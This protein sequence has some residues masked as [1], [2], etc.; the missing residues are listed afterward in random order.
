MNSEYLVS[1]IIPVYNAERCIEKCLVS[2]NKQTLSKSKFEVLVVDDYSTDGTLDKVRNHNTDLN[3]RIVELGENLGP[4]IARNKGIDLARGAYILFLDG[5]DFLVPE[6]LSCLSGHMQNS[7]C[8]LI[9]FNWTYL[10]D[11]GNGPDPKPRRR[12]LKD[13]P[14]SRQAIVSHYLG[15]NMDGSVIFT[16]AKKS[17]FDQYSIR[18]PSG[19]HEDMSVIFKMYFAAEKIL[20]LDE[21]LYIKENTRGSIVNTFS[22]KHVDGYLNAWPLILQFLKEQGWETANYMVDYYRGMSGHVCTLITKNFVI[23]RD[24]FASREVIYSFVLEA[25]ENDQNLGRPYSDFFPYV[26][27]KD[28][29]SQ[30]FFSN[31]SVAGRTFSE[32]AKK[33]ENEFLSTIPNASKF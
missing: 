9:T 7:D 31:M 16:T 29:V 33:F 24:D 18:F 22:K 20:K 28:K 5:D 4:G 26:T 1:V 32:K 11:L 3:M 14:E 25:L 10:S 19:Y 12:D 6:A 8:D 13:M 23:N 17:L 21:I 27:E 30:L 15:M 2:L